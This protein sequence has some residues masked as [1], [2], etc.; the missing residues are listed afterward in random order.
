MKLQ[1]YLL[2]TNTPFFLLIVAV[3]DCF[4]SNCLIEDESVGLG[5]GFGLGFGSCFVVVF[6]V[7]C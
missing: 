7:C 5:L 3:V 6:W 4:E 2:D 1:L